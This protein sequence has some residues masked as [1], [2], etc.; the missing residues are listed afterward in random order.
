MHEGGVCF[1]VEGCPV[2]LQHTGADAG[3]CGVGHDWFFSGGQGHGP[4]LVGGLQTAALA[5]PEFAGAAADHVD[6]PGQLSGLCPGHLPFVD[7]ERQVAVKCRRPLQ[8]DLGGVE[9]DHEPL[10]VSPGGEGGLEGGGLSAFGAAPVVHE[11][12]PLFH[13]PQQGR[14]KPSRQN[15]AEFH[16]TAV[17]GHMLHPPLHGAVFAVGRRHAPL[18]WVYVQGQAI[19]VAGQEPLPR[20]PTEG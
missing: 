19:I 1:I 20:L 15:K 13:D 17:G 8:A 18:G 11:E 2:N 10:R 4:P 7:A 16:P 14:G 9:A 6:C 3:L 12:Y 5:S